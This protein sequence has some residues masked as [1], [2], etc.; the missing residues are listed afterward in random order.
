MARAAKDAGRL[1]GAAPEDVAPEG[2]PAGEA[3]ADD[4]RDV[5]GDRPLDV[6]ALSLIHI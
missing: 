6:K 4:A 3:S 2:A 5:E 1:D